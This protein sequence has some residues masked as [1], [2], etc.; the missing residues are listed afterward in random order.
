MPLS[1]LN[2]SKEVYLLNRLVIV[3]REGERERE[4]KRERVESDVKCVNIVRIVSSLQDRYSLTYPTNQRVDVTKH[5][6]QT[7]N[8]YQNTICVRR[9]APILFKIKPTK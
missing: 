8:D 3:R 1:Q 6:S 2:Y 7:K 5:G 4:R 9:Y